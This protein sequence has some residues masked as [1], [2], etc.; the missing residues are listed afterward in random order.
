[1]QYDSDVSDVHGAPN[2]GTF[3]ICKGTR[4]N[5]AD[6][7]SALSITWNHFPPEW[8]IPAYRQLFSLYYDEQCLWLYDVAVKINCDIANCQRK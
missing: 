5:I 1:M 7:F 4:E 8:E 3:Q 2:I 6:M